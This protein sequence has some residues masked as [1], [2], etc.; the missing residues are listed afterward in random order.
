MLMSV[1][2]AARLLGASERTVARL[3]ASGVLPAQ[4]VGRAWV[5]DGEHLE[6]AFAARP[7]MGR[8]PA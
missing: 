5:I 2:D 4:R 7:P 3:C 1:V 8:R 6:A